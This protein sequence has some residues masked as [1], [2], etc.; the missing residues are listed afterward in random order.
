MMSG[1]PRIFEVEIFESQIAYCHHNLVKKK[2]ISS[3]FNQWITFHFKYVQM[4]TIESHSK[5]NC[6]IEVC[7]IAG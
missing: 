4:D 2:S 3:T 7:S 5:T 6:V 1:M